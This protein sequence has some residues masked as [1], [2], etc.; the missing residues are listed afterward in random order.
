MPS[1]RNEL[2]AVNAIHGVQILL[3]SG[4]LGI[5]LYKMF[6]AKIRSDTTGRWALSVVSMIVV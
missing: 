1:A 4:V 3:A 6:F 5:G 2:H